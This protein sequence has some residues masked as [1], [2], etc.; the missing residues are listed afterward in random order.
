MDLSKIAIFVSIIAAIIGIF[1]GVPGIK[2]LFFSKPNIEV[3]GFLPVTVFDKGNSK[4]TTYPQ[5][6]LNALLKIANPN[7]FDVTVN[8]IKIYGRS[9]DS[10]GKYKFPGNKPILYE[11]NLV[12]TVEEGEDLI[13][14]HGSSFLRFHIAHFE[15]KEAPGIMHAPMKAVGD[16][17]L[18]HPIFHI[19][20]PSFNQLF[21]FNE[22][23]VPY[24]LVDQVYNGELH[25]AVIFNNEL[26]K[27]NPK[28]ILHL[29]QI[30]NDE[31]DDKESLI[32][33]YNAKKEM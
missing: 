6:S 18:G 2:D 21:K 10:S 24:E 16:P 19:Y 30:L 22:R 28:N 32:Q 17:E 11:L 1:G 9:Q 13:K 23:R 29:H 20:F 14:A 15:N 33:I 5:F 8:E 27:I 31:W 12:G 3:V 7:D 25:I 4:D 26:L